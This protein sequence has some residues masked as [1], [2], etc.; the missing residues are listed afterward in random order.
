MTLLIV[1]DQVIAVQ[2]MRQGI[3]WQ[4]L[5]IDDVKVAFEAQSAREI[6][7]NHPIDMI[8]CD[9]EMP[10]ESGI[11]LL[12]WIRENHYTMECII[13]TCHAD[14]SFAQ[15]AVRLN[16]RD[17]ILVPASFEVIAE[18]I[19]GAVAAVKERQ[20]TQEKLHYGELWMSER[21]K[22][23]QEPQ[24]KKSEKV[25]EDIRL[26]ICE[27]LED[28]NLS[29]N[30]LAKQFFL[31]PDYLNRIFKKHQGVSLRQ[32]IMDERMH[33]AALLLKEEKWTFA[34]VAQR[35]GYDNYP[36]FG[37]AFKNYYGY[38]PSDYISK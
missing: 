32:F 36:S 31:N 10:G 2:G 5:G 18:K 22:D 16:C 6:I 26:Y 12:T 37:V 30:K 11:E 14:F 21:I 23:K 4:S 3:D 28:P 34:Q 38:S 8:L 27:H 29:V 35:V 20:E 9:I 15:Q 7:L 24:Y 17:Y 33:L 19:A 25:V 1:N 13:L